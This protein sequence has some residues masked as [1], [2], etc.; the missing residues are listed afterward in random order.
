M[1]TMMI[2]TLMVLTATSAQAAVKDCAAAS[3]NTLQLLS[4]AAEEIQAQ[5]ANDTRVLV[6]RN[7][8]EFKQLNGVGVVVGASKKFYGT[9]FLVDA[10]HVLTNHHVA[11]EKSRNGKI[12]APVTFSVGK[13]AGKQFA[14]SVKGKVIA[15]GNFDGTKE[16]VNSDWAVIRLEKAV[17]KEV[18]YVPMYQMEISKMADKAVITAGFPGDKTQNGKDFSQFYGDTNCKINGT[19]VY[20]YSLHTCQV[21]GGQSG[22]PVMAKG[23]DGKFYAIAMISGNNGFDLEKSE[24]PDKANLAASF[25]S[26]KSVN[27]ESEGDK[28]ISALNA[29]KCE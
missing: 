18:G 7:S 25:A 3:K 23:N 26:G 5:T 21:T 13:G 27:V 10:C 4:S 15:N 20:G 6:D 12:G 11:F 14:Q 8:A 24:N 29:D 28:I 17:G 9:G 2:A 22:S 16:A 1:K 19:S